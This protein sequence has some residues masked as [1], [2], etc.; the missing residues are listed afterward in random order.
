M[1]KWPVLLLITLLLFCLTT[2]ALAVTDPAFSVRITGAAEGNDLILNWEIMANR[3]GLVLVNTQGLR[4]VYD[5]S[6]LQLMKWDGSN[7]IADSQLSEKLEIMPQLGIGGAYNVSVDVFAAISS[8]AK[9]AYLSFSLG[10]AFV[11]CNCAQGQYISLERIRFALRPG[12]S[13]SDLRADSIRLMT[14]AELYTMAQNSAVL[15]N[16]NENGNTSY[17]Y[18]EQ[19]SGIATGKDTLNAP[20]FVFPGSTVKNPD[21]KD[22]DP[23]DKD[24]TGNNPNKQDPLSLPD[25]HPAITDNPLASGNVF[26]FLD[27]LANSWFYDAIKYVTEKGLMNGISKEQFSPNMPMTRAMFATVLYRLAGE[28]AISVGNTFTDVKVG[29]WYT[30]AISWASEKDLIRGY[31]GDKFGT[32]DNITRE[33]VVTILYRYEESLG[34][35]VSERA[36]LDKYTD[37]ASISA[38]AKNAMQWAVGSGIITGRTLATLVPKGETTRAEIAQIL[39]RKNRE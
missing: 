12:K 33:Q 24:P 15:L 28:P 21:P 7:T 31:G 30:A 19:N 16:T 9:T 1:K 6:I 8:D 32:N 3:A 29:Q 23:T 18:L 25:E 20:D 13:T 14:V 35:D 27:V 38:W 11:R 10:S 34:K 2:P 26:S 5:N 37:I 22:P 36:T 4:L 39:A 17:N